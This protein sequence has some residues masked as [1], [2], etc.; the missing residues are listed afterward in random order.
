MDNTLTHFG[1]KGMK[2]GIRRFQPYQKGHTG[3]QEVGEA[4]KKTVKQKASVV[5]NKLDTISRIRS[6]IVDADNRTS[7]LQSKARARTAKHMT[8]DELKKEITRLAKEA[9]A[10]TERQQLEQYYTQLS[11]RNIT[12]GRE[13]AREAL[14]VIGEVVSLASAVTGT[15]IAVQTLRGKE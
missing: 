4:A 12:R 11:G 13:Y 15:V 8:D 7:N 10:Y 6:N 5:S 9:E 2:W 1:I 3:G 14:S